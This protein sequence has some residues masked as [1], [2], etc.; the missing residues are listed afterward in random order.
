LPLDNSAGIEYIAPSK[1]CVHTVKTE[2]G[3]DIR[4]YIIHVCSS[5]RRL[6]YCVHTVKTE[7][8]SDIRQYIIVGN[9]TSSVK[10]VGDGIVYT[11]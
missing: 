4:Q 6:R 1:H 9:K 11:P 3:S 2:A 8:G 5:F 10:F 7:A